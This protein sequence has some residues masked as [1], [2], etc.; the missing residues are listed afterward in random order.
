MQGSNFLIGV[1]RKNG[2]QL[3]RIA[4]YDLK[5]ALDACMTSLRTGFDQQSRKIDIDP[6]LKASIEADPTGN[7]L[8][9]VAFNADRKWRPVNVAGSVVRNNIFETLHEEVEER[10][11]KIIPRQFHTIE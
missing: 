8:C 4:A 11:Q 2:H 9:L 6:V 3:F 5:S 7:E 10:L 1:G